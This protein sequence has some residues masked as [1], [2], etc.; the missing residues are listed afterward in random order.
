MPRKPS[1]RP[2]PG[3]PDLFGASPG[4][5]LASLFPGME[6]LLPYFSSLDVDGDDALDPDA[7]CPRCGVFLLLRAPHPNPPSLVYP[8]RLICL[9]CAFDERLRGDTP[10]QHPTWACD[11]PPPPPIHVGHLFPRPC[12]QCHTA[13]TPRVDAEAE[14]SPLV[15]PTCASPLDTDLVTFH[16]LPTPLP[17]PGFPWAALTTV[18]TVITPSGLLGPWVADGAVVED[19]AEWH[20]AFRVTAQPP[21]TVSAR[22]L[23]EFRRLPGFLAAVAATLPAALTACGLTRPAVPVTSDDAFCWLHPLRRR[24]QF[25]VMVPLGGWDPARQ[26]FADRLASAAWEMGLPYFRG[27]LAFPA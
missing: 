21:L 20:F 10:A 9:M 5:T 24:D 6:S 2:T 12:P 11:A 17:V 26:P 4:P 14:T 3:L 15:C 23:K 13:V 8:D 19:T 27:A 22:R 7:P 1:R 16:R 25:G 18:A